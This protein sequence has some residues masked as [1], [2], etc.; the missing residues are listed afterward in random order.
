[1]NY[2]SSI[3]TIIKIREQLQECSTPEALF[4]RNDYRCNTSHLLIAGA[5]LHEKHFIIYWGLV[6]TLFNDGIHCSNYPLCVY[7]LMVLIIFP[8][9]SNYSFLNQCHHQLS[10]TRFSSGCEALM[11]WERVESYWQ[12]KV[13]HFNEW[14]F[15]GYTFISKR[16]AALF[17]FSNL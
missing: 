8:R 12:M 6:L 15:H 2:T 5:H 4:H 3:C 16:V 13:P 9:R 7:L 1:M 14:N 11:P 17:F 10:I